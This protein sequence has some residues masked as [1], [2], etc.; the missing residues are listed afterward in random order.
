M[1]PIPS[2]WC[3][4]GSFAS[5][6]MVVKSAF[7][8]MPFFFFFLQILQKCICESHVSWHLSAQPMCLQAGIVL[9]GSCRETKPKI[10]P[11]V[12]ASKPSPAQKDADAQGPLAVG[13]VESPFYQGSQ[14]PPMLALGHPIL[15]AERHWS[16]LRSR[17]AGGD[18]LQCGK[19]SGNTY[20]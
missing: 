3:H 1:G 8:S 5:Q 20:I 10:C 2:V 15:F 12:F 7:A 16:S 14:Q 9:L 4:R 19:E 18:A 13:C 6:E 17:L 11:E